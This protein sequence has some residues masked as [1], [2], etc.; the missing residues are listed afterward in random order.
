M[1]QQ[2][3]ISIP[4]EDA[5]RG[6][7]NPISNSGMGNHN[8]YFIT[9]PGGAK[10]T[11][12]LT[13][14]VLATIPIPIKITNLY[15]DCYSSAIAP[16]GLN[17]NI[18]LYKNGVLQGALYTHNLSNTLL[19]RNFAVLGNDIVTVEGYTNNAGVTLRLNALFLYQINLSQP[20]SGSWITYFM[21]GKG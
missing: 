7:I 6:F 15:I 12:S 19:Q 17:V 4:R 16:G 13:R 18:G 10:D 11:T 5:L 9:Y 3:I 8:H 21:N 2:G 20:R 1:G 14:V